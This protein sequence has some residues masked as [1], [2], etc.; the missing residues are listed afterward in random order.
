MGLAVLPGRLIEEMDQLT[1]YMKTDELDG[2]ALQDERTAKHVAWA[3]QMDM[4]ENEDIEERLRQ[5]VGKRFS[6]VLEHAGVFKRTQ[7]ARGLH[8]VY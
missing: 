8:P 6:T 4:A 3:K 5:E 1:E 2:K 7:G